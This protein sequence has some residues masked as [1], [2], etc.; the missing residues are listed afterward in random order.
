MDENLYKE[1][2]TICVRGGVTLKMNLEG[3]TYIQMG[4]GGLLIKC[5]EGQQLRRVGLA[6]IPSG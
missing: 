5:R 6:V 3:A 2:L 1:L 4:G